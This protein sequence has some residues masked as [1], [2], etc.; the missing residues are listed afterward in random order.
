M[1]K[2]ALG[3]IKIGGDWG[4]GIGNAFSGLGSGAGSL[5]GGAEKTFSGVLGSTASTVTTPLI[6]GG[7]LLAGVTLYAL[8]RGSNV[9]TTL[10]ENPE[11]MKIAASMAA[12]ELGAA[13]M[14][15]NALR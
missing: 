8:N 14:A 3:G 9:A 6:I 10:A 5:L 4:K 7:V 12:P 1:G 2:K 11:S 13:S 15:A